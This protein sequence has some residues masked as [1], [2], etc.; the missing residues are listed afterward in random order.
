M[1]N[2]GSTYIDSGAY[3]VLK[4]V[5]CMESYTTIYNSHV[6]QSLVTTQQTANREIIDCSFL[7]L[8][9]HL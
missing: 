6:S 2:G 1:D 7:V 4:Y 8:N 9:Y 3:S 5:L